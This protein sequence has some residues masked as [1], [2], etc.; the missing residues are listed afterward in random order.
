MNEEELELEE[1]KRSVAVN[2]GISAEEI[3]QRWDQ[4]LNNAV[5]SGLSKD[6]GDEIRKQ[7]RQ[8]AE[9]KAEWAAKE[10]EAERMLAE[11]E[12][13]ISR[14]ESAL[15]RGDIRLGKSISLS[16][17]LGAA[18]GAMKNARREVE[19]ARQAKAVQQQAER[20]TE[21]AA[22]ENAKREAEEEK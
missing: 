6:E 12:A 10:T 13:E 17:K 18:R 21:R 3:N 11:K 14:L 8:Q 22:K 20:E 5:T 1:F 15:S 9:R 16:W 7:F 19:E 4:F 2:S